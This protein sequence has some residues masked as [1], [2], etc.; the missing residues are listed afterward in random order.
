MES[1]TLSLLLILLYMLRHTIKIFP[2]VTT[3]YTF[4]LSATAIWM[5][6]QL[7][8]WV[9]QLLQRFK[10][11]ETLNSSL[12]ATI[13]LFS[14]NALK[15]AWAAI[16]RFQLTCLSAQNATVS[17]K[18]LPIVLVVLMDSFKLKFLKIVW[19]MPSALNAILPVCNVLDLISLTVINASVDFSLVTCFIITLAYNASTTHNSHPIFLKYQPAILHQLASSKTHYQQFWLT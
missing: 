6:Y 15:T 19:W 13:W 8:I 14:T 11:L 18:R 17:M 3:K 4:N 2:M 1:I 16:I 10:P 7:L 5:L 12:L 9:L